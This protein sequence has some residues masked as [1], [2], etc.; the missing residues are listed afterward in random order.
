MDPGQEKNQ[1]GDQLEAHSVELPADGSPTLEEHPDGGKDLG[2]VRS[3]VD[4]QMSDNVVSGNHGE[5]SR[6]SSPPLSEPILSPDDSRSIGT[7]QRH[8]VGLVGDV[9]RVTSGTSVNRK[10]PKDSDSEEEPPAKRT[11]ESD[12]DEEEPLLSPSTNTLCEDP[13]QSFPLSIPSP[14]TFWLDHINS[15]FSISPHSACEDPVAEVELPSK[16]SRESDVDEEEL[17]CKWTWDSDEEEEPL[18]SPSTNRFCEDPVQSFPLSNP[19]S[20]TFW[21][22][23]IYSPFSISPESACEDPVPSFT[24][25]CPPQWMVHEDS[26]Q[27]SS[28]SSSSSMSLFGD[29][30]FSP[31][32]LSPQNA[33][34]DPILSSPV[35][36]PSPPTY[37]KIPSS[38]FPCI[39]VWM[40]SQMDEEEEPIPSTSGIGSD[41]IRGRVSSRQVFFRPHYDLSGDDSD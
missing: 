6:C 30:L 27:S 36:C 14:M 39:C 29:H 19:S 34:E 13:V 35:V 23:H 1:Q 25:L 31:F 22:D 33:C 9:T 15:P 16:R 18:F 37:C 24:V 5:A 20:M 2:K 12:V 21:L 8:Q 38:S 26:S 4:P 40:K 10:R 32:G 28:A 41:R 11:R 7:S 17:P 3:D